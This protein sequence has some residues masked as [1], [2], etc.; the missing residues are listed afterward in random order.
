LIG[1]ALEIVSA[2]AS[3]SKVGTIQKICFAVLIKKTAF[4]K[5]S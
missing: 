2:Q 3:S 1:N 5:I 4:L